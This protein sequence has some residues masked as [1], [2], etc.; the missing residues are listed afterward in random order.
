MMFDEMEDL[1]G[2]LEDTEGEQREF[3][4]LLSEYLP[5]T[6][7]HFLHEGGGSVASDR[8]LPDRYEKMARD[9]EGQEG[10]TPLGEWDGRCLYAV[11]VDGLRGIL[12][13]GLHGR[14]TEDGEKGLEHGVIGLCTGLFLERKALDQ[15][16]SRIATERKQ[17]KRQLNVLKE[18]NQEIL[19]NNQKLQMKHAQ[20]LESEIRRQTAELREAYARLQ[21]FF[22]L[23]Q[24]TLDIAATAIFSVDLE[25]RIT[26]VNEAFVAITGYDMDAVI[27]R[28]AV[29]LSG[30]GEND[31]CGLGGTQ[32]VFETQC[33]LKGRDGESLTVL[34]NADTIYDDG[35]NFISRVESFV[36]VTALIR[37][38]EIA[39]EAS[40]AKSEFLANMSHEIR[41]PLN[42]IIGMTELVM[43]TALDERQKELVGTIEVEAG[44]LLELINGILD[45]SKIEAGKLELETIPFDLRKLVEELAA[46]MGIRARQKGLD[47]FCLVSPKLPETVSGD[48]GK[49]RQIL[50]NL[51]GNALKF[52]HEGEIF[53]RAEETGG[54]KEG[55]IMLK[56]SV[57][58]TG[59]GI[60]SEKQAAVFEQ[61]TQA[62]GST[63]RK[64]GGTGLGTAIS[65][66][67]TELMGGRIGMES[68]EGRGSCFW[69]TIPLEKGK[70]LPKES[71]VSLAGMRVLIADPRPT[72]RRVLSE[73]L[74]A[75]GALCS[76]AA[77]ADAA[78][79]I[80]HGAE[81]GKKA[82]P[83]VLIDP[84]LPGLDAADFPPEGPIAEKLSA[85]SF[86]FLNTPAA[87]LAI[88]PSFLAEASG[89]LAGPVGLQGLTHTL[90]A[91]LDP[92]VS[93]E[94]RL[95]GEEIRAAEAM[96]VLDLAILLAED[97][98][99]NQVVALKHLEG[100]G[101][102]V[103]LA[104]NGR[105][106]VELYA[107][108]EYDMI[109]MD[110]QMPE[111]DGF[112]ATRI[113]RSIESGMPGDSVCRV[114]IIAMT[115][116]ALKGYREKCLA[117]DMDDYITKPLKRKTLV[118]M[119]EKWS[120]A[121]KTPA[122]SGDSA[123]LSGTAASTSAEAPPGAAA[124]VPIEYEKVL[125]EFGNDREFLDELIGEFFTNVAG[126]LAVIGLAI[127]EGESEKI[128]K[129]CHSIKG[130]AGNLT[131][132]DLSKA[133]ARL[134]ACSGAG[135]LDA[136]P[137]L[138]VRLEAEVTRLKAFLEGERAD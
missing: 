91:A 115:A 52:T 7:F 13:Y 112:E 84:V 34:L 68:E 70:D 72:G 11:A 53:I 18:R 47:L 124:S 5:E 59:I 121:A 127:S 51:T 81:K 99:T 122:G 110:V 96:P 137:G 17:L 27:G 67:L 3:L 128:R 87:Q 97:Y 41:T 60:A 119:V 78:L 61:F 98:P 113:I 25:N 65:R 118:A 111:M 85:T 103:D 10:R 55:E 2:E 9:A 83:L 136:A 71:P 43:D 66:Q 90:A 120:G 12:V 134:E 50:S 102:R 38:R 89:H 29:F 6:T 31:A 45:F 109:L 35:G 15:E 135:D 94:E 46:G 24:K 14:R 131:A 126:Q 8:P 117:A 76:E 44:A 63:T 36:D 37:A 93:R 42:G 56:F 130:G 48:P 20:T 21:K 106:A 114:P 79:T 69:F 88:G 86:V 95:R 26:E 101:C 54:G 80:L 1:F 104:E 77:S 33:T 129:E 116:H 39:E 107:K 64:Y 19:E 30:D 125:D 23:Q 75:M 58:D 57:T 28:D 108:K 22:R 62:D 82:F 105:Q 92:S 100:A 132:M 4:S 133:A 138:F 123:A 74:G 73:Y 32:P 16:K 49:L 40:R